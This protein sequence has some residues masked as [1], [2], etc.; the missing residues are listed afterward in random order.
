MFIIAA[1]TK[2]TSKFRNIGELVEKETNRIVEMKKIL[3][4]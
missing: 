1:L 2:G 3:K 4:K